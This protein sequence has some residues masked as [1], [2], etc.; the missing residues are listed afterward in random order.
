MKKEKDISTKELC[1]II[2]KAIVFF[3]KTGQKLF[4]FHIFVKYI[5]SKHDE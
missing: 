5:N 1:E 3:K 4:Y 2:V